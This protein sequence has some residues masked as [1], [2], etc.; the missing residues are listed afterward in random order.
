MFNIGRALVFMFEDRDWVSKT[1]IGSLMV[2]LSLLIL[3]FP[4]LLGYVIAI[5]RNVMQGDES[6]P[7]WDNI[8]RYWV[9]GVALLMANLLYTLPFWLLPLVLLFPAMLTSGIST[10]LAEALTGIGLLLTCVALAVFS[11]LWFLLLPLLTVEYARTRDFGALFQVPRL[12]R[13]LRV[14]FGPVLV[15]MLIQFVLYFVMSIT[16]TIVGM[17][18]CIGWL[19]AIPLGLYFLGVNAHLYGQLGRACPALE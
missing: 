19:F 11:I 2:L 4:I 5:A 3:P 17:I 12:L 6:L 10:D 1:L 18:P 7:S 13:R 16:Q 14:C 15:L 9:D 8:G